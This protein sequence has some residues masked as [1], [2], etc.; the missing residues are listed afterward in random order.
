MHVGQA[1]IVVFRVSSDNAKE[2]AGEFDTTPPP[3][4]IRYEKQMRRSERSKPTWYWEPPEKEDEYQEL[5][6]QLQ[7]VLQDEVPYRK[8]TLPE[9]PTLHY[10][11]LIATDIFSIETNRETKKTVEKQL[12]DRQNKKDKSYYAI[13]QNHYEQ[14]TKMI[15]FYTTWR[16]TA[17]VLRGL[18][19][20]ESLIPYADRRG[21]EYVDNDRDVEWRMTQF[22]CLH[23]QTPIPT[24]PR[25]I[26]HEIAR[27]T[28]QEIALR[29]AM[30]DIKDAYYVYG[31]KEIF[32]NSWYEPVPVVEQEYLSLA[33]RLGVEVYVGENVRYMARQMPPPYG[34]DEVERRIA[35]QIKSLPKFTARVRIASGEYTISNAKPSGYSSEQELQQRIAYIQKQNLNKKYLRKRADVEAEMV[36][37]RQAHTPQQQQQ[38][39]RVARQVPLQEK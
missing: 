39:R 3:G 15:D 19:Y 21:Y 28:R 16:D 13:L 8:Y 36:Q 7:A 20:K 32:L 17:Q 34:S 24:I 22:I 9:V 38:Q 26:Q 29:E 33:R 11:H 2:I 18:T 37:R 23:A 10:L 30:G 25:S 12:R 6:E 35:N 14:A 4:E 1:N 27:L 5:E 31:A